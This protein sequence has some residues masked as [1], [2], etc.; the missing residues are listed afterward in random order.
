L[1]RVNARGFR[2]PLW[3]RIAITSGTDLAIAAS[4]LIT[5]ISPYTF[6]E[7]AVHKLTF[8]M[9][10]EFLVVHSTGFFTAFSSND[11]M[12]SFGR[13]SGAEAERKARRKRAM[14][15]IGLLMFYLL[16][17]WGFSVSY[18]SAWPIFAFLV[19]SLPRFPA[20]IR[21]GSGD[22]E[23]FRGMATWAAMTAMYLLG[24]F[25]TLI[26]DIPQLGVT[27]E[28][29]ANQ[30]FGVGGIWPEEP[31]RALAFG[32]IYFTGLAAIGG[33]TEVLDE[34]RHRKHRS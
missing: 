29:I 33:A 23:M 5:W 30:K 10:V 34:R 2:F 14:A 3:A 32:T 15:L 22:A 12:M 16:F 13:S 9:I 1:K 4:F 24:A 27:P 19:V 11:M 26:A 7:R 20:L 21:S 28:V 18:G 8:V 17:A 6:D 25:V 31:Y